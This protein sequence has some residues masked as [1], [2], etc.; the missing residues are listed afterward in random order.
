MR[1]DRVKDG[2]MRTTSGPR[3]VAA[4]VGLLAVALALPARANPRPLPFTYQVESLPQGSGEVEQFVDFVP[5]R[6]LS[7]NGN[8]MWYTATQFQTEIEWGVTDRLE[9]AM[10]FTFVPN[11]GDQAV[12]IPPLPSGNGAKQRARYRLSDPESWPI[13]AA[14]YGEVSENE[15]EIE[16]EAKLILQRRLGS[17]LLVTNLWAER[18][19]YFDGRREWVLNPT[20][21]A[22]YEISPRFQPGIEGWM[23]AEYPD[24]FSG[25]RPFNLGPV[26]YAGPTVMVNL[27]RVW[28]TTGAY[29]RVSDLQRAVAAP[30]PPAAGDAYGHVWVR[31]VVGIGF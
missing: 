9:L 4:V 5:I 31:T 14:V 19:L 3:D 6:V 21:G 11:A 15:R 16:L 24:G 27:G 12:A 7:A 30:A 23:R 13:G 1:A 25:P 22:T 20:V 17:L 26:V 28:W 29:L 10:Y 8:P 18:E 2:P